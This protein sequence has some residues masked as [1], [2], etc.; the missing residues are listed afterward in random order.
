[1]KK[2][3]ISILFVCLTLSLLILG[4]SADGTSPTVVSLKI[5]SYP[6]R[7]V[8]GAFDSFDP[9]GLVVSAVMEDGS[10]RNLPTSDLIYSYHQDGCFRVGDEYITISY[11]GRSVHLP[12]TVN[13]I[14]YSLDAKINDL[15]LTYNGD[16]QSYKPHRCPFCASGHKIEA[17]VNSFGYSAL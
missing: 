10:K 1:M 2:A 14:S 7:T 5:E 13:R 8:Y 11:G 15:T 17:L 16:Y 12:V 9:T 3:L 4:V 6:T